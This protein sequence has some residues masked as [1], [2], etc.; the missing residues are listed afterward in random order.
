V[1]VV[2]VALTLVV[3]L[4]PQVAP[5]IVSAPIDLVIS[6]VATLVAL[7]VAILGWGHYR[8][9]Q[10]TA[11]L[12]RASAFLVLAAHSALL[13]AVSLANL[14]PAFGLSLDDP[15][16]LPLWAGIAA[17]GTAAGLIGTAEV[18]AVR[19]WRPGGWP[20]ALVLGIPALVVVAATVLMAAMQAS[21]PELLDAS[22]L[23]ALRANPG[24][25]LLGREG[26]ALMFVQA[27]IGLVFLAAAALAY[28]VYRRDRRGADGLLSIGFILAA[29]SQL[30]TGFH[31]GAYAS[32]VTTGDLLRVA[33]YAVL[34]AV[35]AAESREDVRD[36]HNANAELRRLREAELERATAEERA[37]LAREIHDGMSQ[38]LWFAKLKQGRL[39]QLPDLSGEARSLAGEVATAIE[40]ALAEARQAI[41]ALR[42]AEGATFSHLLERYVE[43]FSERFGIRADC[44]SDP[45]AE[46]LPTRAQAELLR[47]VQEA[48]ANARKHADA[49]RVGVKVRLMEEGTLRV[50]VTDNGR[51]FDQAA[52]G[53]GSGYGLNSMAERAEIIGARLEIVSRPQ[54]GTQVVVDLPMGAA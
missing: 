41:L 1:P 53:P 9:G 27:A 8:E 7:A 4:D 36:L 28:R 50:T 5:A 34:L 3:L 18:A 45:A 38:E 54:D 37:R 12:L 25:L 19:Q 51:G 32:L 16:Q 6:A 14:Q 24:E 23:A 43:D 2:L 39:V 52:L 31:P 30:H 10:D 17:R 26:G 20:A 13:V 33:F 46:R 44:A 22:A 42:P 15:G 48:L 40:S 11:A 35:L 29:F 49:T 47:I 21:L